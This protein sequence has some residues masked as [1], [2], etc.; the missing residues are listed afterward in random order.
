MA[1]CNI[2]GNDH[3]TP[4]PFGRLAASGEPPRCGKCGS[5]ERHRIFRA[6]FNKIR[7]L[8][9][10]TATCLQFSND[11]SV[12]R[13]WFERHELSVYG[14]PNSLD[15]QRIERKDAA[16][17]VVV[18]NHVLEHVPDYRAA[19]AELVRITKPYGFLFLS[20]PNPFRRAETEDW[21]Y[22]K[23]EE[24]GH[25]R[26]FGRDVERVFAEIVPHVH[27]VAIEEADPVTG[28]VD[29]TYVLTGSDAWLSR[30]FE[31]GCKARICQV[32]RERNRPTRRIPLDWE[33]S[34]AARRPTARS[35]RWYL[36]SV[37]D[38]GRIASRYSV[39]AVS[40]AFDDFCWLDLD[41]ALDPETDIG[42]AGL[43]VGGSG[44]IYLIVQSAEPRLLQL[45]GALRPVRSIPLTGLRDPRSITADQKTVLV[46]DGG[47]NALYAVDMAAPEPAPQRV[48]LPFDEGGGGARIAGAAA[49]PDGMLVALHRDRAEPSSEAAEAGSVVHVESGRV[50]IPDVHEP[51]S[52]GFDGEVLHVLS[53]ASGEYLRRRGE[54]PC[55]RHY[56]GGYLR[57][58]C[59]EENRILIGRS[60]RR[61]ANRLS[62][63]TVR[64]AEDATVDPPQRAAILIVSTKTGMVDTVEFSLLGSE[65]FDIVKL[66]A[67]FAPERRFADP[68]HC[69]MASL[70][71][72]QLRLEREHRGLRKDYS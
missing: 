38:V 56:I 28:A 65:I 15:I 66:P 71:Q 19:M 53:S 68:V 43:A 62:G 35:G 34:G 41:A 49:G 16:Y 60:E 67:G 14:G 50:V 64:A 11:L 33:R 20:F 44:D 30:I 3:F 42:V 2:C 51:N 52:L 25:H 5:V 63:S 17:D 6:I 58:L 59:L 72:A 57:G 22:P 29:L 40:E 36:L 9:F 61:G 7:D 32:R 70:R 45:D 24:H 69:R 1:T 8:T 48:R 12:A 54:G 26:I 55:R 23:P 46:V 27:V 31:R 21:G 47:N 10:K 37:C 18:C 4:G 13:G 39:A